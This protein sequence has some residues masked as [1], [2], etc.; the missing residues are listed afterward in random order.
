MTWPALHLLALGDVVAVEVHVAGDDALGLGRVLDAHVDAA[1]AHAPVPVAGDLLGGMPL[2]RDLV[3][4]LM[5][6]KITT[7]SAMARTGSPIVADDV[8]A[9]RGGARRP[10]DRRPD[11]WARRAASLP[12]ATP[13]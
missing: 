13:R 8:E 6:A 9:R 11:R 4:L 12:A 3:G 7:P 1:D 10:N 5:P 2:M